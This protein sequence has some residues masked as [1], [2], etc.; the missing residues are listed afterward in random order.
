MNELND[1]IRDHMNEW[2]T[3]YNLTVDGANAMLPAVERLLEKSGMPP[4]NDEGVYIWWDGAFDY[5]K[6][7]I[8]DTM[9]Y[10]SC[11][12]YGSD[13][14]ADYRDEA[15]DLIRNLDNIDILQDYLPWLLNVAARSAAQEDVNDLIENPPFDALPFFLQDCT[16]PLVYAARPELLNHVN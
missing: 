15:Y 12:M 3:Q 8:L 14:S 9:R 4:K 6:A 1:H 2:R 11:E 16:S 5:A 13:D 7:M 10:I